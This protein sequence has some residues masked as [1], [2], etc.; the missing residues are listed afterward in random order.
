MIING[1]EGTLTIDSVDGQNN[2]NG[3]TSLAGEPTI[4]VIG[5]WG[6]RD[7]K[8]SLL[9]VDAR[10]SEIQALTGH[11]FQVRGRTDPIYY[12]AGD[13]EVFKGNTINGNQVAWFATKSVVG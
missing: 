9:R 10:P 11:L 1:Y 6:E 2:V 5:V 7:L 13:L 4:Q 12:L 8:V 3:S